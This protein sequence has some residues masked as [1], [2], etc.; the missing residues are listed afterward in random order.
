[1]GK[2]EMKQILAQLPKLSQQELATIKAAC[3]HLLDRKQE[4]PLLYLSMLD[5]LGQKG[6][7]YASFQRTVS[8]KPW[9][10]NLLE[11]SAFIEKLW[12]D[13]TRVQEASINCFLLQL[14]AGDLKY[15]KVAV[16]IGSISSNLGRVPEVFDRSFPG[17]RENGLAGLVLKTMVNR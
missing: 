2:Q 8:W 12:P 11:V 7:S 1:M 10:K 9:Q 16:T 6:P 3:D 17:Y 13:L 14:L 15:L 4:V 5:L